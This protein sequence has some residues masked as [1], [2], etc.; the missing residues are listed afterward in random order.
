ML[1]E[2]LEVCANDDQLLHAADALQVIINPLPVRRIELLQSGLARRRL[3][4]IEVGSI[5]G[6]LG[7][8]Q[9]LH[10]QRQEALETQG[11][12]GPVGAA[13]EARE[14]LQDFFL[15]GQERIDSG[16][17][18]GPARQIEHLAFDADGR[19]LGQGETVGGMKGAQAQANAKL[20]GRRRC[21]EIL[22][23]DRRDIARRALEEH[24]RRARPGLFD[25]AGSE[26]R[27]IGGHLAAGDAAV[28]VAG[29]VVDYHQRRPVHPIQAENADLRVKRPQPGH[30]RVLGRR[31]CAPDGPVRAVFH[32]QAAVDGDAV[33]APCSRAGFHRR[34]VVNR[35]MNGPHDPRDHVAG[36]LPVGVVIVRGIHQDIGLGNLH[37]FLNL[38]ANGCRE[39]LGDADQ[40]Q[41]NQGGARL[42]IVDHQRLGQQRVVDRFGW[43][44]RSDTFDSDSRPQRRGRG[45]SW[46]KGG[47][48]QHGKGGPVAGDRALG[49]RHHTNLLHFRQLQRFDLLLI[50]GGKGAIRLFR[51]ANARPWRC[52]P[53]TPP[54]TATAILLMADSPSNKL[55]GCQTGD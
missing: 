3:E 22:V 37:F 4:F 48:E 17:D 28:G 10:I 8:G 5:G 49:R 20:L 38:A 34:H 31:G 7:I 12:P 1:L 47:H 23:P 42:A 27:E 16:L 25:D 30:G 39:R 53:L 11:R 50:G 29:E 6:M 45:I 35:P 52:W 41:A 46:S 21:V 18:I 9:M 55:R 44:V 43:R 33:L 2:H 54:Q 13:A 26:S 36:N 15:L 14:E 40:V 32:P 24:R 51:A 19:V